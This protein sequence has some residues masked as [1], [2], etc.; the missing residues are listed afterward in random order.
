V[1][2][3]GVGGTFEWKGRSSPLSGGE[4]SIDTADDHHGCFNGKSRK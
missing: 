4:N 1:L 3:L 2:P